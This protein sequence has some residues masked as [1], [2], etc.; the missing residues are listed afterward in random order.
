M[1]QRNTAQHLDNCIAPFVRGRVLIRLS[2]LAWLGVI[3]LSSQS[4]LAE[5]PS[6]PIEEFKILRSVEIPLQGK[7][8]LVRIGEINGVK[9]YSNCRSEEPNAAKPRMGKIF[10]QQAP[11]KT[12]DPR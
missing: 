12:N 2:V 5:S 7:S 4:S 11:S 1:H 8:V 6:R 3:L 10:Q 9:S